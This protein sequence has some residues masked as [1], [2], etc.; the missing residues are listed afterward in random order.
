MPVKLDS[1]APDFTASATNGESFVLSDCAEK[2]VVLYFYSRDNSAGCTNEA[3]A[4][5]AL[6][7]KFLAAKTIVVGISRDSAK[8]HDKFKAKHKLP[9]VLVSDPDEDVCRLFD[10]IKP[11]K[12]YGRE[13]MGVER[14]TFLIDAKGVLRREWRKVKI[15][16]H[17]EEVLA[18]AQAL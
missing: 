13:Y 18:A 7:R 5:A 11:K 14:S 8:S 10:V 15:P 16:G 12:M 1:K 2:Q 4:F 17:A 6:H 3:L 9:F